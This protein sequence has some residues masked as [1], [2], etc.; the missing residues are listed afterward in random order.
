A[1]GTCLTTQPNPACVPISPAGVR[2][3]P[4][5]SRP[6]P[7][8][9]PHRQGHL[10]HACTKTKRR[11]ESLCGFILHH[12]SKHEQRRAELRQLLDESSHEL[13]SHAVAALLRNDEEIVESAMSLQ[14]N[15]PVPGFDRTVRVTHHYLVTG[16]YQNHRVFALDLP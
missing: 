12:G 6:H 11:G 3:L 15:T 7:T 4:S 14:E 2:S 5:R 10:E 13:T 8:S 1:N 9:P 16:C